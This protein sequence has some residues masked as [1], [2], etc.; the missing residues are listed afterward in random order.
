MRSPHEKYAVYILRCSDES[1]YT[2]VTNDPEARLLQH[3]EG[4]DTECYTY[5]RRPVTLVHIEWFREV[6]DAIAAEKQIKKWSRKKKEAL[7]KGDFELL[8]SLAECQNETHAK[9]LKNVS[10]RAETRHELCNST[11]FDS[12]R[13]DTKC[14][15]RLFT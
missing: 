7:I 4:M 9:N 2:G 15:Q 5:K 14:P 10:C 12:A 13:D 1:Y 3:Q 6:Q 11:A 8:R